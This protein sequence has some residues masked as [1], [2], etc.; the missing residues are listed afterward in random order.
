VL[1]ETEDVQIKFAA[2]TIELMIAGGEF[3]RVHF[4][5]SVLRTLL[6]DDQ[7]EWGI[8]LI[9]DVVERNQLQ[10][11]GYLEIIDIIVASDFGKKASLEI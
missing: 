11:C 2:V 5:A 8:A 1:S 4:A 9:L 7:N 10:D 3:A 6:Q